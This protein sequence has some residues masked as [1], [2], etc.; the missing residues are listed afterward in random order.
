MPLMPRF[1]AS[2]FID[3]PSLNLI[4]TIAGS[5]ELRGNNLVFT[6]IVCRALEGRRERNNRAA[7]AFGEKGLKTVD[8]SVI[9]LVIIVYGGT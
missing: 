5:L 3:F 7:L 9:N 2:S 1:P 6:F 8:A 4:S